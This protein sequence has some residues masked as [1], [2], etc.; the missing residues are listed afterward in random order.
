MCTLPDARKAE[1][2]TLVRH[3]AAA[4][5]FVLPSRTETFGLVLL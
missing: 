2:E 4:D 1:G 3:Y 5:V